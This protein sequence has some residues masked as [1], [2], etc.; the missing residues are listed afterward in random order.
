MRDVFVAKGGKLKDEYDFNC[1]YV[2]LMP[3]DVQKL[4]NDL[5]AETI[6]DVQMLCNNDATLKYYIPR[7]RDA[8]TRGKA[9][10][11]RRWI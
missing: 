7:A 8:L 1:K 9:I 4:K 2:R 5:L 11:Y 10:F 6:E 3:E